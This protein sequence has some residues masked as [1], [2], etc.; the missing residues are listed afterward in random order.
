MAKR[1]T[2]P[3]RTAQPH[4]M[5]EGAKKKVRNCPKCGPGNAL[6]QHTGRLTCGKCGYTEFMS[7]KKE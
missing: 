2:K 7:K 3:K 6:A 1:Q 5:F 4:V